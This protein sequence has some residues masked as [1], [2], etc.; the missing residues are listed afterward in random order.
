MTGE[1]RDRAYRNAVEMDRMEAAMNNATDLAQRLRDETAG[2]VRY[3]YPN[4]GIVA[5]EAAK[6]LDRL[7]A[8]EARAQQCWESCASES[9]AIVL[10]YV[11][12]GE[13]PDA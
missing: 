1:E 13:K 5:D 6:E 9:H 2:G 7:Q 3:G 10:R 11:L 8:I 12:E 4:V